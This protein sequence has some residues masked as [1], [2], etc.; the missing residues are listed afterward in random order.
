MSQLFKTLTSAADV[1]LAIRAQRRSLR[2]TLAQAAMVCGV[3]VR[4]LSEL[5]NGKATA[6]LGKTL[7]VLRGLGLDLK[8]EERL[9]A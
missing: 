6:E 9:R 4:F 8:S 5:E 2:L 3:G 7:Q 1:G